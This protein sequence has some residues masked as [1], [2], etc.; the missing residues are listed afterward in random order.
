MK[1]NLLKY[2]IINIL[3]ITNSLNLGLQAEVHE[4]NATAA[5]QYVVDDIT[6]EVFYSSIRYRDEVKIV[7]GPDIDT[8]THVVIPE[9]INVNGEVYQVTNCTTRV[10]ANYKSLVSII[11]SDTLRGF[12]TAVFYGCTNLEEVRLSNNLTS[13][14]VNNFYD[15]TSLEEINLPNSITSIGTC[16]FYNCTSLKDINLP[17][18]IT[19]ISTSTFYNCSALEKISI[20]ATVESINYQA[21]YN[22]NLREMLFYGAQPK[23]Y[24]SETNTSTMPIYTIPPQIDIYVFKEFKNTFTISPTL[25]KIKVIDEIDINSSTT[26]PLSFTTA[27]PVVFKSDDSSSADLLLEEGVVITAE[28]GINIDLTVTDDRFHF[29]S[30]PFDCALNDITGGIDSVLNI[31]NYGT[32]WVIKQFDGARHAQYGKEST[33]ATNS[34]KYAWVVLQ[35]GDKLNAG[36]GYIIAINQVSELTVDNAATFYFP[37]KE[38]VSIEYKHSKNSEV[39]T[40]LA[41]VNVA[42]NESNQEA[43]KGWNLMSTNLLHTA[44]DINIT[45]DNQ[46]VKYVSIPNSDGVSYTQLETSDADFTAYK[47]FFVQAASDGEISL[48]YTSAQ[49]GINA[50]SNITTATES[51]IVISI[52]SVA[53][54]FEDK[55][56]ILLGDDYTTDYVINQDLRK[57]SCDSQTQIYSESNETQYSYNALPFSSVIDDKVALAVVTPNFISAHTITLEEFDLDNY[58]NK[59]LILEDKYTN[60]KIALS[61]QISY[62]FQPDASKSSDRFEIY[63]SDS[64]FTSVDNIEAPKSALNYYTTDNKIFVTDIVEGANISLYSISGQLLYRKSNSE[65]TELINTNSLSSGN[66]ILQVESKGEVQTAK[67]VL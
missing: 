15:C 8:T 56:T 27:T 24:S 29:F 3:I 23:I 46:E 44:S 18:S 21:F 19:S 35:E 61:A 41:A 33:D 5:T 4:I 45:V 6:Y 22:T 59:Y 49:S 52:S 58:P 16:A 31:D 67:I 66:Y 65:A 43:Y 53:D 40:P 32:E 7:G 48:N 13:I 36:E 34:E 26:I 12:T 55:T 25:Y 63:L 17:N 9:S 47:S 14:P 10:F 37:S 2:I 1:K 28:N 20:P 60:K 11:F 39:P 54:D 50:K 51:K 64:A 62:T 42:A 38:S 30:L 57:W